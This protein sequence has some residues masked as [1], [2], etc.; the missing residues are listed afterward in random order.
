MNV[1]LMLIA[2]LGP[3]NVARIHY[4]IVWHEDG[5][6]LQELLRQLA[7]QQLMEHAISRTGG[8]PWHD[9]SH[10]W[11]GSLHHSGDSVPDKRRPHELLL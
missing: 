3:K 1:P 2:L 11:R 7:I 6:L 4:R 10:H 5:C 9:H 8:S